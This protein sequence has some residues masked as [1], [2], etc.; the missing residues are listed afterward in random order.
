MTL[1]SSADLDQIEADAFVGATYT[2]P[3]GG[4][5]VPLRVCQVADEGG[6]AISGMPMVQRKN[7]YMVPA[8]KVTPVRNGVIVLDAGGTYTISAAPTWSDPL[9]DYWHCPVN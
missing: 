4:A 7:A 3:A 9:R 2:P 5:A 8:R 6:D 1:Y